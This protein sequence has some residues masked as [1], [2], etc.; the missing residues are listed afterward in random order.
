MTYPTEF[1]DG[2]DDLRLPIDFEF[3]CTIGSCLATWIGPTARRPADFAEMLEA[4][5]SGSWREVSDRRCLHAEFTDLIPV[6]VEGK[7]RTIRNEFDVDVETGDLLQWVS[8][9]QQQGR[10]ALKRVRTFTNISTAPPPPGFEWR[11]TPEN[12]KRALPD[13]PASPDAVAAPAARDFPHV[14]VRRPEV[15]RHHSEKLQ[16]ADL[17]RN[18]RSSRVPANVLRRS[19][20]T[21]RRFV[22]PRRT[23]APRLPSPRPTS[24]CT[25]R[26][27]R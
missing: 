20:H 8:S 25:G 7:P 5:Q 2:V 3:G 18:P 13:L 26:H 27:D 14:P 12:I 22:I 21:T 23:H 17:R 19:R 15:N 16:S 4:C 10:E 24:R 1:P 6:D 9:Q 11:I